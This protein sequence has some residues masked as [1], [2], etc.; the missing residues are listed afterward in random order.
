MIGRRYI[1]NESLGAGGMGRSIWRQTGSRA[2]QWPLP[3]SNRMIQPVCLYR[4]QLDYRLALAQEFK[5]LASL[6]HPNI[7]SVLD[8]GFDEER[9]PYY[10]MEL[11][12]NAQTILEAGDD[13]P[14]TEQVNLLVQMLQALAYLHRR[15]I[16]H[17]DLKPRNVLVTN[18]QVKVLDFGLSIANEPGGDSQAGGTAG[19]LA[20]MA[21]EVLTGDTPSESADLY[22]VG[23]MAYE[24]FT[25]RHPYLSDDLAILLNSIIYDSPDMTLMQDNARLA[26]VVGRLLTKTR[27]SRYDS[28][29]RVI[30]NSANRLTNPSR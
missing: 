13:R 24:L 15:G 29:R 6:R 12:E 17:R 8:Y 19:T 25:G 23:V 4:Q 16:I 7:I 27:D 1:L 21:P 9:H 18:G 10:T 11:L 3:P 26:L 20:Y 2:A 14:L 28:A 30:P 5:V 22:A